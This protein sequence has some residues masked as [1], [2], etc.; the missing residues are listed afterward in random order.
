M[1]IKNDYRLIHPRRIY[2]LLLD[3]LQEYTSEIEKEKTSTESTFKATIAT[4]FSDPQHGDV[5][6]EGVVTGEKKVW[7]NFEA[8]REVWRVELTLHIQGNRDF[9]EE[10]KEKLFYKTLRGGG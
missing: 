3:L 7:E 6:I 5:K 4:S 1:E 8:F 2:S 10:I 9:A